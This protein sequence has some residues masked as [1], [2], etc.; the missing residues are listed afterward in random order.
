MTSDEF[1]AAVLGRLDG[2]EERLREVEDAASCANVNA[3]A[4]ESG[5]SSV[6]AD[7]RDV[8]DSLNWL[9]DLFEDD[10]DPDGGEEGDV[11]D[12]RAA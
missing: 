12:E 5:L 3:S 1:Q 10:D 8:R 4:C 9:C 11:E 6:A 7:L 2:P